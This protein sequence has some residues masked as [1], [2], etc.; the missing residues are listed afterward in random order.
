LPRIRTLT[1]EGT[2]GMTRAEFADTAESLSCRHCGHLGL[3]EYRP[4][5]GADMVGARCPA[6]LRNDPLMGVQWLP[7][8][9][10][11]RRR[12]AVASEPTAEEIWAAYGDHCAYCGKP[13]ALCLRLRIGLE[14]QHVVPVV[15]GGGDGAL[16]PFCARCQQGSAAAL[17]ETRNIMGEIDT[18]D[19]IIKRIETAHPELRT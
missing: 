6:C 10:V 14:K 18:L 13:K 16:I 12:P 1:P 8:D 2:S 4:P 7:K 9:S 15:L 11:A 17:K 19:G 3:I 5:S